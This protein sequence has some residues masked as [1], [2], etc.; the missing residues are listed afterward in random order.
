MLETGNRR[1]RERAVGRAGVF[2]ALAVWSCSLNQEAV[3]NSIGG[4]MKTFCANRWSRR[5]SAV[6]VTILCLLGAGWPLA[7]QTTISTGSIQGTI[8][9][10]TGAVV[11]G[12]KV[13]ITNK[14][15]SESRSV[16]TTSAGAY[17][18]G[19]LAPGNYVIRAE[20]P[21]FKSIEKS[22]VIQVGVTTGANFSLEV[23]S[24][25]TVVEV[26]GEEVTVNTEQ[27]SVQGVLN[28]EQIENLPINGRN[29]LD[30][31]QLEP[32]VQIQDGSDFDPTKVG[33]SSISFGG[34]F[35]RTARI[36]VDRLDTS[37]ETVGTTTE[38]IPSS[39]IQ[40]F[41]ISQ[42]T[43]DLSNE[44]TSSGAVNVVTRS[45]TSITAKPLACSATAFSPL[46][47]LG[48][49]RRIS[50]TRMAAISAAAS[51]ATSCFSL[52]TSSTPIKICWRRWFPPDPLAPWPAAPTVLSARLI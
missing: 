36:E 25:S 39:D 29:F 42:S 46:H 2:G 6:A 45:G 27:A 32:G 14:D 49:P 33:F 28:K 13:T 48:L 8:V 34:R 3:R 23:G 44:L 21:G 40:E 12:A 1:L 7:A 16:L 24:S 43:L 17:A 5:W 38:N 35:G 26:T 37:D 52:P 50:A 20:V 51:F 11:S 19:S 18:S 4:Y 41:Q 22:V 10:S 15:T 9:D 47:C 30:L 31:A